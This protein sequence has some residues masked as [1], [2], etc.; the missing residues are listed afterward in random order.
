MFKHIKIFRCP[1]TEDMVIFQLNIFIRSKE[2]KKS[3]IVVLKLVFSSKSKIHITKK[4]KFRATFSIKNTEDAPEG[5]EILMEELVDHFISL[6]DQASGIQAEKCSIIIRS[7]ILEKPIQIPYRT[8]EQ[9]NA[10][11]V[12][13]QFDDV[14]QSGKNKGRPSLYS[15]PIYIEVRNIFVILIVFYNRLLWG[16]RQKKPWNWFNR[17]GEE[18]VGI[19]VK[20]NMELI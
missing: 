13:Q 15:Q 12:M 6:A 4:K 14:D 3:K 5:R 17:Q 16:H 7:E 8:L 19:N 10:Q 20:L 2:K 11:T 1:A 9:N 18:R